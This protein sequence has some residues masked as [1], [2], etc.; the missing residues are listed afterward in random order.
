MYPPLIIGNWKMN[1]NVEF[2]RD[3][4]AEI[5]DRSQVNS[6]KGQVVLCPSFVHL[7]LVRHRLLGTNIALGAQD[8][9]WADQGAY[10]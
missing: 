2:A 8:C 10:T 1:G 4:A 3:L 5:I 7:T 6:L 9:H